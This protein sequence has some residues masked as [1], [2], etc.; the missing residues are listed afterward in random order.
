MP[1]QS[2]NDNHKVSVL[3]ATSSGVPQ[4]GPNVLLRV[5]AGDE[6]AAKTDYYYQQAVSP[7]NNSAVTTLVNSLLAVFANPAAT[8]A[9][10]H[11][12]A[13]AVAGN[14]NIDPGVAGFFNNA[15]ANGT[16]GSNVPRAYLNYIFFDEQFNFVEATS[17]FL[18]VQTAG[19]G[20]A[21][22]MNTTKATKNGYIYV[23]LSNETNENV[24]FDNFQVTHNRGQL[25]AEDNYYT[26]GLKIAGISSKAVSNSLNPEMTNYGYQGSF[27]EEVEEF[28]LNYNEFYL[29][30]YDP[31]ID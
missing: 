11:G 23:Y 21:L 17:G 13:T 24:Y 15:P 9:A 28:G 31:Q 10:L 14:I 7:G 25:I 27:R 1:G 4:T 26:Y 8:P 12:A 30:N 3:K 2:I 29:R 18:R 6:V 16:P 5:I 22:V 20:Q 19:D